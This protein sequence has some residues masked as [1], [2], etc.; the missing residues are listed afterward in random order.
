MPDT[1]SD[2]DLREQLRAAGLRATAARV[3]VLRVLAGRATASSHPEIT[4]A[5]AEDGWDR[6]T[7]YRNLVD[8]TEAGIL[9]RVD[10][11][12]HVWRYELAGPADQAHDDLDHPHF[13]CTEC[14]DVAC[15]PDFVLP[16]PAGAVPAAVR[17]GKVSI[18]LRGRCDK[19]EAEPHPLS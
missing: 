6:A 4:A 10:L 12:D 13:L 8:L 9:R 15:L 2:A 7:L 3:A 11:G 19:C 14:G 1:A 18:Q 5:R 17:A 16:V